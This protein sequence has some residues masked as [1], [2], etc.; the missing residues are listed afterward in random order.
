MTKN[1]GMEFTLGPMVESTKELGLM[2][3]NMGQANSY[4]T[5]KL[6]KSESGKMVRGSNGFLNQIQRAK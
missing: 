5:T 3:S 2:V 1:Q 4:L 6:S